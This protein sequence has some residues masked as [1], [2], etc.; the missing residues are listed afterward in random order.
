MNAK[1]YGF[2]TVVLAL[3]VHVSPSAVLHAHVSPLFCMCKPALN[4]N[5]QVSISSSL[6]SDKQKYAF[7]QTQ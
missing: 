1:N 7:L 2:F 6:V 4:I 3:F 5:I